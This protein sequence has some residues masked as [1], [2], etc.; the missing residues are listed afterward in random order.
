MGDGTSSEQPTRPQSHGKRPT[1]SVHHPPPPSRPVDRLR[2]RPRTVRR[3]SLRPGVP[4]RPAVR[5]RPPSS[6][7]PGPD[8]ALSHLRRL[9]RYPTTDRPTSR[10]LDP[11]HR[12]GEDRS[13]L[14]C[15][16]GHVGGGESADDRSTDRGDGI[17]GPTRP[18]HGGRVTPPSRE[19]GL[20]PSEKQGPRPG[21]TRGV[22]GV[23]DPRVVVVTKD[24]AEETESTPGEGGS[25][26]VGGPRP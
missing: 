16:T 14:T 22:T 15:G 3:M 26:V 23:T 17:H 20:G 19:R 1:G 13:S 10:R 2:S 12:G 5:S 6:L 8:P 21:P 4:G 9:T 24:L 7:G 25:E 18:S 11:L